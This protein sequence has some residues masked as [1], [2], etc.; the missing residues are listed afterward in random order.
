[1]FPI[2]RHSKPI[3]LTE[4]DPTGKKLPTRKRNYSPEPLSSIKSPWQHIAVRKYG[5]M[6]VAGSVA[7]FDLKRRKKGR[8]GR[9]L[10]GRGF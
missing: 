10:E 6:V 3:A 4:E 2:N 1:M 5:T 7:F 8:G 9:L